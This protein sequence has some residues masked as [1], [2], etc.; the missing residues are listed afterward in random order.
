MTLCVCVCLHECNV[1]IETAVNQAWSS[2]SYGIDEAARHG[3]VLPGH[4]S[5]GAVIIQKYQSSEFHD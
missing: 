4:Y 1:E 3:L 5:S 2:H